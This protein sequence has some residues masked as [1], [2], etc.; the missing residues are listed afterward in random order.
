MS[1]Q[2]GRPIGLDRSDKWA[3]YKAL[4]RSIDNAHKE[5]PAWMGLREL[6][7]NSIDAIIRQQRIEP[8][9]SGR[10][11]VGPYWD[12]RTASFTNKLCVADNGISMT[13]ADVENH[14]NNLHNSGND[15]GHEI[16]AGTSTHKGQGAKTALL[17]VNKDGMEYFLLQEGSVPVVCN[18]WCNRE[19][20]D[21]QPVYE[22]EAMSDDGDCYGECDRDEMLAPMFKSFIL[23]SGHGTIV[24]LN[25]QDE[26]DSTVDSDRIIGNFAK[27]TYGLIKL[28][29]SRYWKLPENI[30]ISVMRSER[31]GQ[32]N[33][34][35]NAVNGAH[36][37]LKN[38]C[39]KDNYG[40]L[41]LTTEN[42]LPFTLHW[43]LLT[44]VHD[45]QKSRSKFNSVGHVGLLSQNEIYFDFNKLENTHYRTKQLRSCGV[46]G[47]V[48]SR[49]V[50]YIEPKFPVHPN[51]VRSQLIYQTMDQH[52]DTVDINDFASVIS[53]NIPQPI[54]D[55]MTADTIVTD[56]KNRKKLAHF[57]KILESNSR[58]VL[59]SA[60]DGLTGIEDS[61]EETKV[62]QGVVGG[63]SK[64]KS[65][66]GSISRR[67]R[68]RESG[69]V[70]NANKITS[71]DM[72]EVVWVREESTPETACSW[73]NDKV[74]CN[75]D[76]A[77]HQYQIDA[78]VKVVSAKM[79]S[80]P[81]EL[82]RKRCEQWYRETQEINILMTI[83]NIQRLKEK[84][85]LSASETDEY[86]TDAALSAAMLFD[87][88][89][90]IQ[91]ERDAIAVI[92]K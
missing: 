86:K 71:E 23:D 81:I 58:E 20:Y 25:G 68:V 47:S 87:A 22:L 31:T 39:E 53:E 43:Y 80:A 92:M 40:S 15:S 70:N 18:L 91:A 21:G 4:T 85:S 24:K 45:S 3:A 75:L 30:Q 50:F 8:G 37:R 55:Q 29:E 44:A 74:I 66:G 89:L 34:D 84:T 14:L 76:W 27:T 60:I 57:L 7:Q 82:V 61:E 56:K 11:V 63:S 38:I 54:I 59:K 62:Q 2:K 10:V 49:V 12:Q 1:Q 69:L 9:F 5:T 90:L 46:Y 67:R 28:L 51:G 36:N 13:P 41:E 77:F 35:S 64:K 79:E 83:A 17:P 16:A 88:S 33:Q 78:L 32:S 42:G 19:S 48:A 73:N 52:G 65:T 6:V 26:N 72:P